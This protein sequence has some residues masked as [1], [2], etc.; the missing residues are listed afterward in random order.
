MAGSALQ[1]SK[2]EMYDRIEMAAQMLGSRLPEWLIRDKL[3][4]MYRIGPRQASRVMSRARVIMIART[5]R[6]RESHQVDSY[7]FYLSEMQ[8]SDDP[9]VRI[10][11]QERM[12]AI[13]GLDA[14]YTGG[15]LQPLVTNTTTN[16]TIN[17]SGMSVDEIERRVEAGEMIDPKQLE[18][19]GRGDRL[20]I[21]RKAALA[22]EPPNE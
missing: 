14:K 8:R 12:D 11:C 5:G 10:R 13:M 15:P 6:P 4:E 21:L 22:C 9:M 20:R 18:H 7:N 19:L 3:Q 16:V 17:V 1:A 2:C